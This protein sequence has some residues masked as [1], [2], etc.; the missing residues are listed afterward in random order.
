MAELAPRL[1]A[2]HDARGHEQ[3]QAA[4]RGDEKDGRGERLA[5]L[6]GARHDVLLQHAPRHERQLQPDASHG[7]ECSREGRRVTFPRQR[8]GPRQQ[9]EKRRQLFPCFR[10][11]FTQ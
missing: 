10:I 4:V 2:Q 5:R 8:P 7:N 3:S 11:I 1:H 9:Q 6:V